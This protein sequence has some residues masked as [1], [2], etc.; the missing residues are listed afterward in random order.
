[1]GRVASAQNASLSER[2]K[3]KYFLAL[4]TLLVRFLALDYALTLVYNHG[5]GAGPYP[6]TAGI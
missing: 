4:A 5:A 2:L 3:L 1:M 6:L